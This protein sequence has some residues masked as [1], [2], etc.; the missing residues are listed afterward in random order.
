MSFTH[1][2]EYAYAIVWL[3]LIAVQEMFCVEDGL[4]GA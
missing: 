3:Y 2:G 1:I 4:G